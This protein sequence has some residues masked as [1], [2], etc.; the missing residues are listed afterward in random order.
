MADKLLDYCKKNI[1]PGAAGSSNYLGHWHYTHFYYAQV[2][3]RDEESWPKYFDFIREEIL[4]KQTRGG[5]T[6]GGWNEGHVGPVYTTA[7]NATILQLDNG[8][9]PIYQ[10]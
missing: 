1:W 6:D 9:L 5:P 8:F 3:Y 4:S 7:I 10:R 2:M